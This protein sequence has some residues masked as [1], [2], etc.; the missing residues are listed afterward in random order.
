MWVRG[1]FGMVVEIVLQLGQYISLFLT[2]RTEKKGRRTM[3]QL[4]SRLPPD[5]EMGE[6]ASLQRP[7]Q[8]G[9]D[10]A[11]EIVRPSEKLFFAPCFIPA[12]R[13]NGKL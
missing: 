6:V 2:P 3:E 4:F 7:Y 5:T 10:P 12:V 8:S 11:L 13:G 9:P 1:W